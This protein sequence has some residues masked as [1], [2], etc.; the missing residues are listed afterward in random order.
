MVNIFRL[1]LYLVTLALLLWLR[2]LLVTTPPASGLAISYSP[3]SS[4]AQCGKRIQTEL[5]FFEVSRP[6]C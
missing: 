5:I 6:Y 3:Y 2:F 1:G 4:F